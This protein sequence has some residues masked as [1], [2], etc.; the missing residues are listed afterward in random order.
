MTPNPE[1]GAAVH[2][3]PQLFLFENGF[4]FCGSGLVTGRT[5]RFSGQ[6]LLATS[7]QE[8]EIEVDGRT[9]RHAAAV[10]KPFVPKSLNASGVPFV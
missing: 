8:F 2:P 3:K 4:L 9:F 1:A 6:L 5:E 7:E 10:V